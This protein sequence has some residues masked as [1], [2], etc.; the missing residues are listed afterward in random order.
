M[1]TQKFVAIFALFAFVL[2][3]SMVFA[4]KTEKREVRDFNSISL[5]IHAKVFVTQ[6]KSTSVKIKGDADDLDEIITEV[7]GG[8]LRIKRKKNK[9]WGWNNSFK[10]IEIYVTSATIKNLKISGSGNIVAKSTIKT[11]DAVYSIS[12][13]G[14][15]F[16]ED[17]SAANVEC[18]ISGSGDINLKGSE[19][20]ELEIHISG[21]GNVNAGHLKSENVS[22]R[23]SGSGDC[24]VYATKNLNARVAGSGDIYYRGKPESVDSKSAGSGSIK[25]IGM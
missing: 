17:L 3:G 14:N 19:L 15:I 22:V 21:S 10:N 13:S 20:E 9:S 18:H 16:I 1:K 11:D 4:Q 12:G 8:T 5:S 2:S 7:E 6:D 23:V 24:K 25:S